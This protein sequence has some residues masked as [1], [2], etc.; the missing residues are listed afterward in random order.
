MNTVQQPMYKWKDLPWKKY[1]RVVFKLQKRI[2]LASQQT[3]VLITTANLVR[4]RVKLTFH[5]RF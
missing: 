3:K 1:E 2:Y 5:A 4:S